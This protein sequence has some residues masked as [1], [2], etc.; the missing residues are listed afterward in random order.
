MHG[1][2]EGS[3]ALDL[4]TKASSFELMCRNV[5]Q[6]LTTGMLMRE[7]ASGGKHEK[8]RLKRGLN[9]LGEWKVSATH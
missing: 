3:P 9:Y 8:N 4:A 7:A 5:E 2:Y 6:D 1:K